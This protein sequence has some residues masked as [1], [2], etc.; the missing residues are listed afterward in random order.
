[1]FTSLEG[2]AKRNYQACDKKGDLMPKKILE[3]M[4]MIYGTSTSFRVLNAKLCGL[5]QGPQ[6]STKDKYERM[7]DISVALKE[8]H[9]DQFQ[10]GEF[11]RMKKACFFASL[12]ENYKYLVSH[13]KDQEDIDPVFMLK[14]IWECDESR[15]LAST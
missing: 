6:E 4:D 8:Y 10:L 7:V 9:G 15:Y 11:T 13:L 3:K 14:E 12:R 2:K 1:M 5:T